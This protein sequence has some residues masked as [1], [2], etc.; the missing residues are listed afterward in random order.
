MLFADLKKD[1]WKSIQLVPDVPISRHEM[2]AAGRLKREETEGAA[3]H[4]QSM[5]ENTIITTTIHLQAN[6]NICHDG[7]VNAQFP[8]EKKPLP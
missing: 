1:F 4:K 3:K 2:H 8:S 5:N 6:R 7:Y